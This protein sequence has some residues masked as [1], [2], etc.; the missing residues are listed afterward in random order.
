MGLWSTIG[1]YA[2]FAQMLCNFGQ[3]D[4][5]RILGRK[6][7]ELMMANHLTPSQMQKKPENERGYGFGLGGSVRLEPGGGKL[8]TIG[9]F[10]WGGA[11]ATYYR[12]DTKE[13]LVMLLF[14]QHFGDDE[15]QSRFHNLVYQALVD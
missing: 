14:Q 13:R 9:D 2:R 8:G 10:G 7:V 11:A 5:A 3:L 12:V 4:G 1:D 6:T 15:P